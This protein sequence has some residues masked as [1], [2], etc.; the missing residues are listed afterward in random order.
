MATTTVPPSGARAVAKA[1]STDGPASNTVPRET[2]STGG[3]RVSNGN[4]G[5]LGRAPTLG[6]TNRYV[7]SKVPAS[8]WKAREVKT[9]LSG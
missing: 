7:R 4:D 6:P 8:G 9:R 3:R 2:Y 5:S 1:R